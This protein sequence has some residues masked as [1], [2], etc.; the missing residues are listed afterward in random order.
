MALWELAIFSPD[1]DGDRPAGEAIDVGVMKSSKFMGSGATCNVL[2]AGDWATFASL[3]FLNWAIPLG[4]EGG[5]AGWFFFC[6][7]S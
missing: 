4:T 1:G 3:D 2:L 7:S 5:R 6:N